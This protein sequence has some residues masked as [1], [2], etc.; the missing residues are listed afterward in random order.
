MRLIFEASALGVPCLTH[1]LCIQITLW[2]MTLAGRLC[3]SGFSKGGAYC[4]IPTP[5]ARIPRDL[6]LSLLVTGVWLE[7]HLAYP[8]L[9]L[10]FRR[11]RTPRPTSMPPPPR[12]PYRRAS[13]DS[14]LSYCTSQRFYLRGPTMLT[15]GHARGQSTPEYRTI[16]FP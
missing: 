2:D 1:V 9:L 3:P 6:G 11:P 15:L 14:F 4:R 7:N 10:R 13:G 16:H 12:L 5:H 8:L